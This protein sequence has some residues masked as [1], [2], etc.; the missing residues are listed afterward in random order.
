MTRR[1][2]N[3]WKY[4]TIALAVA[5]VLG[6]SL[7]RQVYARAAK[8][9]EEALQSI[10]AN[11]DLIKAKTNNLPA[12]PASQSAL[13]SQLSSIKTD[14]TDIKSLLSSPP[15]PG[16]E[17]TVVLTH[18]V[19][20]NPPDGGSELVQIIAPQPG[21]VF[22]GHINASIS[23]F[24]GNG[25]F[26]TCVQAPG[27]GADLGDGNYTISIRSANS[28]FVCTEL[29]ISIFDKADGVDV[30]GGDILATTVYF[31]TANI[32]TP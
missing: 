30:A 6:F 19:G 21:K 2:V 16:N 17:P 3:I 24:T 5:F 13:N 23:A 8:S 26:F 10:L 25:G 4:S 20:L 28:D 14:T 12:D 32:I 11:T 29:Q 22:Y 9:V 7:P 18:R 31:Q 27:Y 15:S 1:P